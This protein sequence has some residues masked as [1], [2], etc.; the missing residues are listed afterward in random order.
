MV[1]HGLAGITDAPTHAPQSPAQVDLLHMREQGIIEAPGR[2]ESLTTQHEAGTRGP[3]HIAIII[4]LAV[5]VLSDLKDA[6]PAERVAIAVDEASSGTR[7]FET[8]GSRVA[9]YLGLARGH[10]RVPFQM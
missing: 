10:V 1:H 3:E 9:Q 5:V 8:T 2:A 4:V 7:M 6:A